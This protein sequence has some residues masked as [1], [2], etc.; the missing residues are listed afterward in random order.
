M[1]SDT[2]PAIRTIS[3]QKFLPENH[4]ICKTPFHQKIPDKCRTPPL[5]PKT[6]T[7]IQNPFKKVLNFKYKGPSKRNTHMVKPIKS[8]IK[9]ELSQKNKNP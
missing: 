9:Q 8:S 3:E 7:K 5:T 6:T 2:K 4:I 1:R